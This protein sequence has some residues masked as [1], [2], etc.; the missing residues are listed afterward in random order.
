MLE[1]MTTG[2]TQH[3]RGG[4]RYLS[5]LQFSGE[6]LDRLRL[7]APSV[8]V[9][10]QSASAVSDIDL[11]TWAQVEVLHTSSVIPDPSVAPRLRWVQLDTAGIDHLVGHPIWDSD[12]VVTT[13]AGVSP[14]PMAEYVIMMM[15]ALSH[16]LP[17]LLAAQARH[18]WPSPQDRWLQ[19]LPRA[20]SGT[21]MG[22]LGYGRIGT[23]IGRVA[24]TLGLKVIGVTR[25][26]PLGECSDVVS[27]AHLLDVAP[28]C[29]WL[30]VVT[31]LTSETRGLVG[32]EVLAALPDGAVLINVSRGG[33][34]DE[35]AL[36]DALE[37]GTLAGAVLDVFD[38]EPLGPDSPLWSHPRVIVTPHVSGFAPRYEE[39]V[40]DLVGQNLNR[41]LEGRALLNLVDRTRGY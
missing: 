12:V 22:I 36:L 34:V 14:E 17:T 5:T 8:Q 41:F 21:T 25:T 30:V 19:F 11:A 9:D 2:R 39:S 15:L 7:A 20:I 10:Q 35:E 28:S 32:A 3:D 31:P 23:E 1:R 40:L 27:S 24:R 6:W 4:L 38:E 16:H 29:D 13:I 37:R 26:E 18:D 33:V